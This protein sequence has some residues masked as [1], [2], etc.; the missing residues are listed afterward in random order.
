MSCLVHRWLLLYGLT[1]LVVFKG[2]QSL[3]LRHSQSRKCIA[4]G[5]Q[6]SD[7]NNS[8]RYWA[9]M[10][11]N[12]LNVSAQFRR[13]LDTE[14]LQNIKTGG[15]LAS[16]LKKPKLQNRLFIHNGKNPKGRNF[17]KS[18]VHR[19]KQTD[20]G[21]LFFYNSSVNSCAQP[22]DSHV[23]LKKD[24]CRD[25]TDQ[26][27]SFGSVTQYGT[28]MKDVHC[29]PKQYMM[30]TRADYGDFNESGAFNDDK[31]FDKTCSKL[32]NCQVK[33]RC[34]GKRS[35]ELTMDNNLLPSPYCS[36][37]SKEIYA[38]YTCVDSNSSTI[39][40]A[41]P[42]IRLESSPYSGYIQIKYGS[43]WRYVIEEQWD[44]N[45]QKTLCRH[46]GF[47][48]TDANVINIY[49]FGRGHEFATGDLICYT[50]QSGGTSCCI[51]L[52]FFKWPSTV[53]VPST[54]CKICDKPL[55]NDKRTFPDSVFSGSGDLYR[56]YKYARITG[57]GWCP[58]RSDSYLL[59]DLHKEYHITRVVV[60]GD[61]DQT[62]WSRSYSLKY[63]HDTTYK[64]CE[65]IKGNQ[66]GYQAS[67]TDVDIYNVRHVKIESTENTIFCLRIELC[68]EVQ[69]PAP[70]NN[71][72]ITPYQY[73]ALVTW[74]IH[75]APEDSSYITK[76]IIYLDGAEYQTIS[77]IRQRTYIVIKRFKPNT[78]YRVEIQTEDGYS[79]K[80]EKVSES[81][82]TNT[83]EQ[84]SGNNSTRLDLII[85]L[86]ILALCL[87]LSLAVIIYQ[88]RRLQNNNRKES[89]RLQTSRQADQTGAFDSNP[90][91]PNS[92]KLMEVIELTAKRVSYV[93]DDTVYEAPDDV[94]ECI[95]QN[96]A[97]SKREI[98]T[99]KE[100]SA[101]IS[102]TDN[103]EPENSYQ[104]LLTSAHPQ[105]TKGVDDQSAFNLNA[106]A[107]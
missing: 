31:N 77:Q 94:V 18:S 6:I 7:S 99:E 89:H 15:T 75:T 101:Y 16:N 55:L 36:D 106:S 3:F 11:N 37:T 68:G 5:I 42:N 59:I 66:N 51:H 26:K 47:K 12:C 52:V 24:G 98:S 29:S 82:T 65:Q 43:T 39:I 35:C 13:Y 84:S 40:T 73:A 79:Q 103:K 56:K 38:E 45:R 4:A 46:L 74:R 58:W 30:V 14:L 60:M 70:V 100:P 91:P 83:A 49:W 69:T 32:A 97:E 8:R 92:K 1:L 20:A 71:I 34:G 87:L 62:M 80:S 90:E 102:L 81:F 10:V 85:P 96:E 41:A 95:E 2:C 19:L 67:A 93:N 48:E 23:D 64:N 25:V 28:K 17:Q 21:S 9:E 105:D 44:K 22:N 54:K 72:R 86:V 50:T 61:R 76:I 53:G 33:S 27:F 88:R 78:Q 63:S 57:G 104:P 107:V